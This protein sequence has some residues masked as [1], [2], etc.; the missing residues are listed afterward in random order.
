MPAELEASEDV[1]S[2]NPG[3]D[4]E[5][6]EGGDETNNNNNNNEENDGGN[7]NEDQSELPFAGEEEVQARPT[8]VDYLKSPMVTLAIG[9][10]AGTVLTAHQALLE[11]SPYF[12]EACAG[13]TDGS[14][15]TLSM[16]PWRKGQEA[17][18]RTQRRS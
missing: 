13:F 16:L 10:E 14:V 2:T 15:R 6:I 17:H 8:F 11:Q 18:P 9:P 1:S 7:N 12:K 4:V 3:G 5:M